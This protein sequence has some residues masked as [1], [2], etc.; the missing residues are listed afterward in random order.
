M[1]QKTLPHLLRDRK[2]AHAHIHRRDLAL[3]EADHQIITAVPVILY[4][5]LRVIGNRL[6]IH[7]R[8]I[9]VNPIADILVSRHLRTHLPLDLVADS[10][11]IGRVRRI[12]GIDVFQGLR[13]A[14][15]LVNDIDPLMF[16][17]IGG[18]FRAG[19]LKPEIPL[20]GIGGIP[21]KHEI[22]LEM[23]I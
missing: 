20:F 18:G 19:Q 13:L 6:K 15:G 9:A 10:G 1:P 12:V 23:D 3:V 11:E 8:H 2:P 17:G 22:E 16:D 5:E 21:L 14:G 7:V 4:V